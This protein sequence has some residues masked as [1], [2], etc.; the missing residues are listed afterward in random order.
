MPTQLLVNA[1]I[2]MNLVKLAQ[3]EMI[4][5]VL[6]AENSDI[7]KEPNVLLNAQV[8]NMKMIILKNAN[9]AILL[10]KLV[11]VK[12]LIFAHLVQE[13]Y[14]QIKL[15]VKLHAQLDF[16]VIKLQIDVSNA[17]AVVQH[18]QALQI[19]NVYLVLKVVIYQELLAYMFALQEPMETQQQELVKLVIQNA[20]LVMDL[21]KLIATHVLSTLSYIINNAIHNA[22][23]DS[24]EMLKAESV[25]LVILIVNSVLVLLIKIAQLVN[26]INSS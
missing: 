16:M 4:I 24:M 9:F 5:H 6:L 17:M 21:W 19:K 23:M 15:L 25:S 20:L 11:K 8:T 14:S 22:Q 18:A 10:A 26:L 7:Q 3:E 12:D 2:V 13:T 1:K